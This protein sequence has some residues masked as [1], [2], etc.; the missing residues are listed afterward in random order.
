MGRI[1]ISLDNRPIEYFF[2]I[3]KQEY[4]YDGVYSHE[5]TLIK[6]LESIYD[7][8]NKRFQSY[9]ENKTPIE[10]KFDKCIKT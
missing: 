8:N 7:Y 5:K 1:G 4:L 6:I 10:Y 9:L 3:L 2:S